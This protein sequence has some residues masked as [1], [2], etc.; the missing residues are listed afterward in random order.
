MYTET[1][2]SAVIIAIALLFLN[3]GKLTMPESVNSMLVVVIILAFILFAAFIL[4]EKPQDERE[5][6]HILTAGRIS[7]L[8]GV[9]VLVLGVV[10][11]ATMHKIDAWLIFSLCSMVLSKILSRIY[12]HYRM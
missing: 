2:S 12:S 8:V 6:M 11:Q 1:L 7:F 3:P 4:K 10:V 5:E 9:G